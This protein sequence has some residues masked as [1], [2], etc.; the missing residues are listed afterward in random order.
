MNESLDSKDRGL[1]E[2]L[3][4]KLTG[5]R[6]DSTARLETCI[7]N[8]QRRMRVHGVEDLR[9]YL[10]LA[11]DSEAEYAE[12]LSAL[13]IHTTSWF[14]EAPHFD[15]LRDF[16]RKHI[17]Q[18]RNVTTP[19]CFR[20]LSAACSSGEEVYTMALV[21]ES[22]RDLHPHFEY[23]IEGWDIDPVS[24]DKARTAIYDRA[25]LEQIPREHHRHL[26]FGTGATDGLFTLA[27]S[28]R[29][30]CQFQKQSLDA[31]VLPQESR[32][33]AVFCRNVLIY[34][35]AD[36]VDRIVR[37]LLQRL[38]PQGMLF[39]GH[40]E[41]IDARKF[42]VKSLGN[43]TYQLPMAQ[44]TGSGKGQNDR[45]QG[46]RI[47]IIDASPTAK[48]AL[49]KALENKGC[50]VQDVIN[51]EGASQLLR[52]HKFDQAVIDLALT[53]RDHNHWVE[54]Q[55]RRGTLASV[56]VIGSSTGH[57]ASS[58]L[59]A[60]EHGAQEFIDK[61]RI[62]GTP[63]A[64]ATQLLAL[65]KK[66]QG[67]P[68]P[69]DVPAKPMGK[70]ELRSVKM[71]LVGA[72]TGG[73]EALLR[74]LKDMPRPCP[75]VL[76]VQHIATS[77]AR[78]FAERLAQVS[79]LRLGQPIAGHEVLANHLYMA[80][81]DYHIGLKMRGG[82]IQLDTNTGPM[83]HSVRPAVDYLFQSAL[84]LKGTEHI[85]AIILTG[86]GKDGAR[87]L[88]QL[89]NAGAMTMTQDEQ[90]SVVYGMPGEAVA[91]GASNFS[92]T[93]EQI[94]V[95]MNQALALPAPQKSA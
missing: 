37:N 18:T 77:F 9:D 83:Q 60:L 29:Q 34:F 33:H 41:G 56:V 16:A 40:S 71:I 51:L 95:Q 69:L 24:L 23:A 53:S 44:E 28:I 61:R 31:P 79:G 7:V 15:R 66:A 49:R 32:F 5:S 72:S 55:R 70:P 86:M 10:H 20:V 63:D 81:D 50:H 4:F 73:T 91:L 22:L 11:R 68:A 25:L 89:K 17:E 64:I 54:E 67:Q 65:L 13:T 76:V 2:E 3:C 52:Q 48:M 93:P 27:K 82:I 78:S 6:P 1:I 87:G 47:L 39:L 35:K 94:R 74:L 62:L 36:S 84:H 88:L 85:L 92:G 30:R 58:A 12:L 59:G 19:V 14:R 46:P 26:R 43:A 45:V 21:L 57:D 75:P 90:S 80:W 42:S 8:L 38:L